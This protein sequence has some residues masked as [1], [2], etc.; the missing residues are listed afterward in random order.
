MTEYC[1]H[2]FNHTLNLAKDNEAS[3]LI[4]YGL[5]RLKLDQEQVTEAIRDAEARVA[6][7]YVERIKAKGLT[8]YKVNIQCPIIKF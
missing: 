2:I 4:Y 6:D 3:L 5:G 8:D 1:D 7:A